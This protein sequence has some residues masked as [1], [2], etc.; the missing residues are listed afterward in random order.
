[1]AVH[2]PTP[3]QHHSSDDIP[4][5]EPT[6]IIRMRPPEQVDATSGENVQRVTQDAADGLR[7]AFLGQP[8]TDHREDNAVTQMPANAFEDAVEV[9]PQTV[10]V[11]VIRMG[12]QRVP[13][14]SDVMNGDYESA[15]A[16]ADA[17]CEA[18]QPFVETGLTLAQVRAA[19]LLLPS[20][21][22]DKLCV[23]IGKN[24]YLI[25]GPCGSGGIGSTYFVSNVRKPGH[26]LILKRVQVQKT[27][28]ATVRDEIELARREPAVLNVAGELI[29]SE[30][31]DG[32]TEFA[33]LSVMPFHEGPS[34]QSL[35]KEAP[36]RRLSPKI[37][38]WIA[39]SIAR[40]LKR[41]GNVWHLDLKGSNIIISPELR[42]KLIDFG[43]GRIAPRDAKQLSLVGLSQFTPAYSDPEMTGPAVRATATSD[44]YSLLLLL[45]EMLSG[46]PAVPDHELQRMGPGF[47][48]ISQAAQAYKVGDGPQVLSIL[49]HLNVDDATD[50][51]HE[52]R[53]KILQVTDWQAPDTEFSD[54]GFRLRQLFNPAL[55]SGFARRPDLQQLIT[56]LER[57]CRELGVDTEAGPPMNEVPR[58]GNKLIGRQVT[59]K[60][61]LDS[62]VQ[63][64]VDPF[65]TRVDRSIKKKE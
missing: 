62:I 53:S 7:T 27:G 31:E 16:Y 12:L 1:M 58:D 23:G 65:L 41:V 21:I 54:A 8:G 5:G 52:S 6:R 13:A 37:A 47:A 42:A 43:A 48:N 51:L 50:P 44:V 39:L 61:L 28:V 25:L 18:L 24:D 2:N 34:L 29:D 35:L 46:E 33:Q 30:E 26:L 57:T 59:P 45:Y 19:L 20:A 56:E 10:L 11:Q 49:R 55:Q 64:D 40:E 14:V 3:G 15:E 4:E 60:A 36:G 17:V 9:S 63:N 38:C 32:P 22:P